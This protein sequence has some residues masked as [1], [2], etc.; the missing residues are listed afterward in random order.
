MRA[1]A[2]LGVALFAPCCAP[3]PDSHFSDYAAI[4]AGRARLY[5]YRPAGSA[6]PHDSG[7]ITLDARPLVSLD[8]GEYVSVVLPP[9]AHE[10]KAGVSEVSRLAR[11]P[12]R[13]LEL[14]ADRA[15]YCAL[16]AKSVGPIVAWDLDCSDDAD[17]HPELRACRRGKLDRTVDWQP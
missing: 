7:G 6:G 17:A 15:A 13:T 1:L 8:K 16:A 11:L 5:V 9:G 12:A 10:L 14:E 3:A 4:P 2:L